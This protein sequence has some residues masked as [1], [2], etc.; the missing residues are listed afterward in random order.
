M[1]PPQAAC[2]LPVLFALLLTL[3]F[4]QARRHA[5]IHGRWALPS[6][7][8]FKLCL[9]PS[10][11]LSTPPPAPLPSQGP[12][13]VCSLFPSIVGAA[14]PLSSADDCGVSTTNSSTRRRRPR[15]GEGARAWSGTWRRRPGGWPWPT[16]TSAG[17][18]QSWTPP[19]RTSRT[20]TATAA[21]DSAV[22]AHTQYR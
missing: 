18:P 2:P 3:S 4:P 13:M 10:T 1:I 5:A 17:S 9:P 11:A 7:V 22:G 14:G 20:T 8:E 15:R 21:W 6:V 19:G 16:R 12:C